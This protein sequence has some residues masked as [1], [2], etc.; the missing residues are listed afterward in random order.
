M[1]MR[2]SLAATAIMLA[3]VHRRRV[4][5]GRYRVE[6]DRALADPNISA[7]KHLRLTFD[8]AGMTTFALCALA[9]ISRETLRKIE[10]EDPSVS[11]ASLRR[12]ARVL[13]VR[14]SDLLP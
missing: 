6:R 12:V 7:A 1:L 11:R 5:V 3:E 8:G 14:V 13:G 4:A 2:R 10:A 9:G